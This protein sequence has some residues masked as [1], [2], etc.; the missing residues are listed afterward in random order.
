[1]LRLLMFPRVLRC[2]LQ[3]KQL[4][5]PR[6]VPPP[7]LP[8]RNSRL[9]LA[10]SRLL[11]SPAAAACAPSLPQK[12]WAAGREVASAL[13]ELFLTAEE[14]SEVRA[15]QVGVRLL[16]ALLNAAGGCTCLPHVFAPALPH[17]T[18]SFQSRQPP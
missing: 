4:R 18:L 16:Q 14:A 9:P 12:E 6:A 10:C 7:F 2:G 8:A 17:H 1:M 15:F 13:L 3:M 5:R 11:I